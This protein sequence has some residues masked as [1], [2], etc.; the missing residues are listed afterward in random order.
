M[1]AGITNVNIDLSGVPNF[2]AVLGRAVHRAVGAAA[3]SFQGAAI[4]ALGGVGGGNIGRSGTS[5]GEVWNVP[6]QPGQFP[7]RQSGQLVNS[8]TS[9]PEG[10]ARFLVGTNLAHGK[11]MEFGSHPRAKKGKYLTVPLNYEASRLIKRNNGTIRGIEGL[12][13][14]AKTR[15]GW[16]MG[17]KE[18][19]E[20]IVRGKRVTTRKSK[21]L[22]ALVPDVQ[23]LPRPWLLPTMANTANQRDALGR[24]AGVIQQAI[25]RELVSRPKAAQ[26]GAA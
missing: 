12:G 14:I 2:K 16:L 3:V 8:V 26:A 21:A 7:N 6:S 17:W 9:E 10:Y 23:I 11:Y 13:I 22:F 1:T 5:S 20:R 25:Q 18:G 19:T 15:R 4:R 24:F